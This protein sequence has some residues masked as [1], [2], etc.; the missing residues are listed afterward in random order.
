MEPNEARGGVPLSYLLEAIEVMDRAARVLA[1]ADRANLA[2]SLELGNASGR[3][4]GRIG[5]IYPDAPIEREAA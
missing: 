3:L 4:V 5:V 1:K 2:L